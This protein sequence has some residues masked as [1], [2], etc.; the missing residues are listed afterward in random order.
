MVTKTTDGITVSVQSEYQPAYSSPSQYHYVFTYKITI[1]NN[2][3]NTIQVKTR[4]WN[5]RD[6]GYANR[7]ISGDSVAGQQPVIEPGKTHEYVSGCTLKSGIGKMWGYYEVEKVMDGK[8]FRVNIPEF[9]MI[10]PFKLN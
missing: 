4:F 5:I 6:I 1:Q 2:G 7:N 3:N 8:K 10:V 9:E